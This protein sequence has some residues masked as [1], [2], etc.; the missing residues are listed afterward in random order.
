MCG[1]CGFNFEDKKLIRLM[2]DEIKHRGPNASG[3]YANKGISLGSRRLSIIDLSNAANQPIYNEDR[4]IAVVYNGEIFNFKELKEDLLGKGHRFYS[5]TDTE[6]IVHSYEEYGIGCLNHFNGFWGLALYDSKKKL[7]FLA[8]DRLG[9]KPLYYYHDNDNLVFGSEIKS[10]LLFGEIKRKMNMDA[11]NYFL[12]Y[13]YIPCEDT[14]FQGIKR[15]KPGYYASYDLK[16]KSLRLS[17]Y[18][19]IHAQ[20]KKRN[21]DAITK[22][23]ISIL[24]DSIKK[25]LISDVP[26]GVYL[27]GG[28]DSSSIVAL[29]KDL[30]GGEINTYSLG[31]EHDSIGNELS[32]ARKISEFFST[33]HHEIMIKP[34]IISELPKIVWH[35][36]EPMSDPAAV[37]VYFLSKEARK[38]VTVILAGDGAD[39]LFAGYEQYKFMAWG[40]KARFLPKVVR[41]NIASA[42]KIMPKRL[43]DRAYKYSSST[44]SRMFDR[45]ENFMESIGDNKSKAYIEVVGVFD[46]EEEKEL[47]KFEPNNHYTEINKEFFSGK[48]RGDFLSQ[49]AYFDTKRYLPEDLLMKPDKMC[50]A[51]S[52]E[53]RVPYLDYRLVEYAFT[54]PSNLKLRNGTA[55]YILKKALKGYLPKETIFRK[56]Q[57]FQ[58]PLG[59]WLSKELRDVFRN[60][61]SE[62]INSKLFNKDFVEKIFDN[63]NSSKLYYGRQ[64][65]SLGIFNIWHKMYIEGEMVCL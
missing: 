29:M 64:L 59:Q 10:I 20:I 5:D 36:D 12:T 37:P 61:L 39:E 32:Y 50:M 14:I 2:C 35:L 62:R 57:P 25:R 41:K 55:K 23:I 22:D 49:L 8:R 6:V 30:T 51:H 13:R 43:L 33:R 38:T 40:N 58:M 60:L 63:Y 53:A 34:D 56:K 28:I 46:E 15:I 16:A 9:I 65:W 1:I 48:N 17:K 42:F 21:E 3:Y 26:L 44:G 52:I 24:K 7:L 11:F 4:T 27:S 31:F 54:I 47:L 45:L 18:W 19:D